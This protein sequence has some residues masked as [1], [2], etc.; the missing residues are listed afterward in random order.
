[1]DLVEQVYRLV[2]TFPRKETYGLASQMQRAAV[3]VPANI[4]EGFSRK[5]TGEYLRFISIAQASLAELETHLEI[6]SRVAYVRADQIRPLLDDTA[7]LGRQL[8]A[9]Q[10]A[11]SRRLADQASHSR[12][13]I[14]DSASAASPRTAPTPDSRLPTRSGRE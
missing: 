13:L 10:V 1:M 2:Q 9:L 3:S 5:H 6:A 8:N 7:A 4:A 11:L 14:P 12:Y